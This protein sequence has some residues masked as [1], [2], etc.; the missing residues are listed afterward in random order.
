MLRLDNDKVSFYTLNS[1]RLYEVE[2]TCKGGEVVMTL[3][4]AIAIAEPEG[5]I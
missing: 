1:T 5:K 2:P 3:E 4:K